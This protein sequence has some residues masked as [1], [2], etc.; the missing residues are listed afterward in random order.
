MN[1]VTYFLC[2]SVRPAKSPTVHPE[3]ASRL[4]GTKQ[5]AKR[6]VLREGHL[7]PNPH[8][9]L[10]WEKALRTLCALRVSTV[11]LKLTESVID[12][13]SCVSRCLSQCHSLYVNYELRVTNYELRKANIL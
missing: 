10:M 5:S 6:A 12:R 13:F 8:P 1:E 7:P 9:K 3:G 4:R 2:C 11:I